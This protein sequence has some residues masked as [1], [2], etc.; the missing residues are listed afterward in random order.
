MTRMSTYPLRLLGPLMAE[1]ERL[2]EKEGASINQF[3]AIAVAEKVS[4]LRTAE[5]FAE[6]QGRADIDAFD[7]ILDREGGDRPRVGDEMTD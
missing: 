3:V 6:R 4:V 5:Y 7:R 2:S 1:V